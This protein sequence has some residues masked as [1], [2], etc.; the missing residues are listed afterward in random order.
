MAMRDII[1]K[2]IEEGGA[3]KESLLELT[4]T[5]EKGLA[6]QFT[7]LRMMGHCPKKQE[8]G[9]FAI[10][11]AEE[12]EAH[13]A[14]GGGSGKSLTPAERV[15]KARKRSSRAATAYDNAQKRFEAN[16]D[17]RLCELKFTKAEAEFEIAEIELGKAEAAYEEAPDEDVDDVDVPDEEDEDEVEAE[18]ELQ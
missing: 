9:T 11:S 16:P 3:T 10:V 1:K 13:R 8:D 18:D 5:T 7:Y 12:W 14:A 2:A 6:S 15:E 4:G 17:D